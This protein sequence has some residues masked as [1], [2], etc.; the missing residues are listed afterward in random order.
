MAQREVEVVNER[1]LNAAGSATSRNL[2]RNIKLDAIAALIADSFS[3]R[4]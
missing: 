3:D 2:W 1:G 4:S